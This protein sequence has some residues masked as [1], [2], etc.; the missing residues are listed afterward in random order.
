MSLVLKKIPTKFGAQDPWS[1]EPWQSVHTHLFAVRETVVGDWSFDKQRD[2]LADD[3][4]AL[5]LETRRATC[6][7]LGLT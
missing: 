4:P 1:S 7:D 6:E 5:G 2:E 3:R